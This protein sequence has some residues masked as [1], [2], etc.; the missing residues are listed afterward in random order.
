MATNMYAQK[1]TIATETDATP[2]I[3][4]RRHACVSRVFEEHE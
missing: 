2:Y 4:G 3:A 1:K